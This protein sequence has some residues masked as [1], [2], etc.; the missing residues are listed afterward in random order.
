MLN[1]HGI[2]RIETT[3]QAAEALRALAGKC[4]ATE[5]WTRNEAGL[6]VLQPHSGLD[7]GEVG[8]TP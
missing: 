6:R 5:A 7:G 2:T 4:A 3:H 1:R 8:W